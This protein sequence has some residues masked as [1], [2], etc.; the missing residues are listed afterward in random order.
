M[1][2]LLTGSTGYVGGA[3][4][5]ALLAAGH[6]VVAVVRSDDA[7]STLKIRDVTPVVHD[8]LDVPW[9]TEA[10]RNVDGLIHTAAPTNIAPVDLDNAVIDAAI[11][12]FTGTDKPFINTGGMWGYGDSNSITEQSPWNP[13]ETIAWRTVTEHRALTS[14]INSML[15][16]PSIS[17]GHAGGI[18][19]TIANAPGDAQQRVLAIGTGD[20][21]VEN[22]YIDDLA[23]LYIA[24]LDRGTR[25]ETYIANSG[26]HPTMRDLTQAA[27]GPKMVVIP[28]GVEASRKRL[29]AGYAD[30]LILDQQASSEKA[31]NELGWTP[32][33]P[34]ILDELS[35]GSYAIAEESRENPTLAR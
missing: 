18:P 15:V 30:G 13:N 7:A 10:L 9:L 4:L 12:A 17:Y 16:I 28:E 32:T 27:A 23:R 26:L 20:Q 25:G 8:L 29:G 22:V 31:R 3:V 34:S 1:K 24:V 21:H 19:N 11:A 35:T 14:G 33:G 6:D 5:R 2:V